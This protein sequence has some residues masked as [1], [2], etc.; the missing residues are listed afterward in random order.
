MNII[1]TS[2]EIVNALFPSETWTEECK[3]VFV[4]ASR[5]PKN[6]EQR[7]VFTKEYDM[8]VLA[9][10]RGHIIFLLPEVSE[11]KNPDALLDTIF[12]EFKN[13]TGG[14]N[15]VSHRFRDALHQG[16]NVYLKIDSDITVK[17]VK[18]I[19]A[20]VLKEK[21]STGIVFCYITRLDVLYTWNM[22]DLKQ[23]KAP[24]GAL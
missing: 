3:N 17:R 16:D 12:T 19:L 7:K 8:A 13:V 1:D 9:A 5:I 22:Q 15:A 24:K 20:G 23:N 10:A 14:E 18:Q 2:L 21:N 6:S 4:A 11:H